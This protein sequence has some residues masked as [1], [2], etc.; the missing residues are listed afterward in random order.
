MRF[1]VG[2]NE[3]TGNMEFMH[4]LKVLKE[5]NNSLRSWWCINQNLLNPK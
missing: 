2:Q 4:H 5:Y 3:I 1:P